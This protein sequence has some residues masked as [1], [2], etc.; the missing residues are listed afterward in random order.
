[1]L[2]L[3]VVGEVEVVFIGWKKERRGEERCRAD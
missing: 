1:M 3:R 2:S